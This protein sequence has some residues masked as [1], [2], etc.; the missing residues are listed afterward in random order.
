LLNDKQKCYGV[1]YFICIFE[2]YS[3]SCGVTV[4]V[5]RKVPNER[6]TVELKKAIPGQALRVEGC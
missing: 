1:E 4:S 6:N 5:I 3:R 2:E